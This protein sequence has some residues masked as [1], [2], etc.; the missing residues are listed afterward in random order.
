MVKHDNCKLYTCNNVLFDRLFSDVDKSSR[1]KGL[2]IVVSESR[3]GRLSVTWEFNGIYVLSRDVHPR[4][5]TGVTYSEVVEEY[6]SDIDLYC[7]A[8]ES[9]I[10]VGISCID[11]K[12]YISR[13]QRIISLNKDKNLKIDISLCE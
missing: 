7:D 9:G 12:E 13:L 8:L 2:D 11:T 1:F 5:I 4:V 3:K 6:A 10:F